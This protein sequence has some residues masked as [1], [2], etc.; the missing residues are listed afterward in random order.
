MLMDIKELLDQF[1]SRILNLLRDAGICAEEMGF[2]AYA[3]GGLVR[4]LFLR[5]D[6]LDIDVV[7]EGD[8]IT[9]ASGFSV[10]HNARL[11]I[12]KK[13]GTANLVFPNGLKVDVATARTETYER[14][15]ALPLVVPGSIND[16]MF[17]RDFSIN[18][19]AVSLN[20]DRFGKLLDLFQARNDIKKRLIRVLHERSFIDDPTRIFR[21]VRFE[22]RFG[23]RIES[24]TEKLIRD[25]VCAGLI[26][27][28]SGHR[29][30]SELRLILKEENPLLPV[31]RLDELGVLS[32]VGR[33]GEKHKELKRLL[34]RI[35]EIGSVSD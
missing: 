29:I 34:R 10:N 15:A 27:R 31:R 18:T 24:I 8:G 3:V 23:F 12:Y 26:E 6:N 33:K 35:D 20:P 4:D 2:C 11:L 22:K 13:F 7:I 17:R 25:A 21:A 9:F 1:P 5:R 14:P 30:S 19:L 28:L 16:D 32:S